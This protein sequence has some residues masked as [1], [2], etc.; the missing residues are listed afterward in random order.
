MILNIDFQHDLSKPFMNTVISDTNIMA[1]LHD[2]PGRS[3]GEGRGGADRQGGR[4]SAAQ[5]GGWTMQKL[6]QRSGGSTHG[7][8]LRAM[9]GDGVLLS[10]LSEARPEVRRVASFLRFSFAAILLFAELFCS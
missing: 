6:S 4:G 7:Q 3:E 1:R 2:D 5:R 9:R 8:A 10:P